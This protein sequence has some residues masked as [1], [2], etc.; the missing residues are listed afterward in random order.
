M[1]IPAAKAAVGKECEKLERIQAW[2]K[3]SQK[4]IW[5]DW[6]SKKKVEKY[7]SPHWW[8]SVIWRM[9]NWRQSTRNTKVE[10]CSEVIL[11][12]TIRCLMQYSLNKGHQHHKWQRQKS[13]ISFPEGQ[14]VQDKQLMQHPLVFRSKWKLHQRYSKILKSECPDVWIRLPRHKWPKSWSG[15]EDPVVPLERNLYGHPLAGHL[16][17]RQFEKILLKHGWVKVSKLSWKRVFLSVYVDDIKL[18]GKKTKYWSDA[19]STKQRSWLG[20]TN[21]FTWS[22]ISDVH[23]KTMWKNKDIVDNYRTKFESR[24][25]AG[26]TEKLPFSENLHGLTLWK[27]MPRNVWND[28]VSWQIR[29]LNNSTKYLLHALMTITSKKKKWN[30]L[31]ICHKYALNFFWY[32]YAWHVLDDL[33]FYGQWTNLHDRSQNGPKHVTNDYLVWSLTFIIRVN[34]YSIAMWETLPDNA[35]WNC[36]KTPTL[37]EILRTRNLLKVEHCVFSEGHT[38]VPIS[39]MCKKQTLVSHSSTESEI[40]SLDAGLRMGWHT[41]AW[42]MGSDCYCS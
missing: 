20:R 10:L 8:T 23:S 31:E 27:V 13:W 36:F 17:E 18:A 37:Q 35:D 33:I 32:A 28:T 12:K 34:T 16:L 7:T 24:I 39:W 21:I 14:V 25:S 9:P 15:M 42:L 38:F 40:I 29:R 26:G 1:K 5:S 22:C 11:W 6:W 2:D 4:Q 19:E 30:L 41:R 3:T